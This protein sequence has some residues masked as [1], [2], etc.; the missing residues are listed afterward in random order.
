MWR[1]RRGQGVACGWGQAQHLSMAWCSSLWRS[2]VAKQEL[3]RPELTRSAYEILRHCP[4]RLLSVLGGFG[5]GDAHALPHLLHQ[6]LPPG[7]G[8]HSQ[9]GGVGSVR[10]AGSGAPRR[11]GRPHGASTGWGAGALPSTGRRPKQPPPPTHTH[12]EPQAHLQPLPGH[13]RA[14]VLA[15]G[16]HDGLELHLTVDG[17]LQRGLGRSRVLRR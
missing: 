1:G 2:P 16:A 3:S 8:R 13:K 14:L 7:P 5:G 11:G 6:S 17:R 12:T 10:Q 15:G 9:K 4:Q